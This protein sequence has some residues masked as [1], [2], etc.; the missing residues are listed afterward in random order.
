TLVA[1]ESAAGGGQTAPTHGAQ[2]ME[3]MRRDPNAPVDPSARTAV[4]GQTSDLPVYERREE[5]QEGN[6]D[7]WVYLS[8]PFV[9]GEL[10]HSKANDQFEILRYGGRG[11]LHLNR[12]LQLSAEYFESRIEQRIRPRWNAITYDREDLESYTFKALK[13]EARGR[14]SYRTSGGLVLSGS[15]GMAELDFDYD[16]DDLFDTDFEDEV[17]SGTFSYDNGSTDVIGDLSA[18]WS[19]RDNLSL[20]VFYARDLV[21]SAVKQYTSDSVGAVAR[22]KPSDTWHV[23]LRSQY[24]S[25]EDDNALFLIQGESFWEVSQDLGVWL[26]LDL[27][28]V[29]S[30][31]PSDYYWTPYWDQ[32]IMGVLRY[33]QAWQGYSFRLDLLAGLQRED[34]RPLRR[35]DDVELSSKADWD[36]AL[37]VSSTFNRRLTSYLDLFVDANVMALRD[38]IDHRFLFGFN[39]GF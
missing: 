18:S 16:E 3:Q 33:L 32:R 31:D 13:R 29:S 12:N 35:E 21:M 14:L 17:G 36:Y 5:F 10:S 2:N 28:S 6:P 11:G 34:A 26:G 4:S 22:W 9:G 20:Y 19:P 30:S 27:S 8:H 23:N 15:L 24:W 7:P 25:Y 38:Y 1:V 37:G 39:L